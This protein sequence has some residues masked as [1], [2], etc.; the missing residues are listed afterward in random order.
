MALTTEQVTGLAPD[1]GA[2]KNGQSLA[3]E[4]KWTEYGRHG[5][6]LWGLCQGSGSKPYQVRIDL[7][8]P[9]YK[10]SC[11]SFKT[12]C[13]HSLGL[14]FLYAGKPALFSAERPCTFLTEW[15]ADRQK[16]AEQKAQKQAEKAGEVEVD[17]ATLAKRQASQAKRA[18]S[19]EEKISAGLEEFS[20][21]LRDTVREGLAGLPFKPFA[22]WDGISKR[23]IDAQ[24]PGLARQITELAGLGF[25]GAGW[26]ERA[27]HSLARLH[28]ACEAWRRSGSLPENTRSDLRSFI[29]FSV[30][31]EELLENPGRKDLW[32]VLARKFSEEDKL[33]LAR[34]WLWS[35]TGSP[36]VLFQFAFMNQPLELRMNPG[37]V[38]DAE[39]VFFPGSSPLRAMPKNII[40]EQP[41]RRPQGLACLDAVLEDFSR[42]VALNPW[43]EHRPYLLESALPVYHD[44]RWFIQDPASNPAAIALPVRCTGATGWR[45]MAVSGGLP[46]PVFGEW[47]GESFEPLAIFDTADCVVSLTG[48][49]DK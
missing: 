26:Q 11:P 13:K 17:P 45:M 5:D 41:W 35:S 12:P 2:A 20:L 9:A 39:I 31:K 40:A 19:R 7:S 33:R 29:G 1:P 22:F 3:V 8:G 25:S 37:T 15:L 48:G 42:Q 43:C 28:L 21:L 32:T 6:G 24:A 36:A 44:N 49:D 47:D 27:L 18:A 23:L 38:W 14:M 34:T 46:A 10:C 30:S 4:R 16:R